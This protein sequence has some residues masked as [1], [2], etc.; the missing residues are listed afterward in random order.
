VLDGTRTYLLEA[1]HKRPGRSLPLASQLPDYRPE[2][3][4]N[5]ESYWVNAGSPFTTEYSDGR[6]QRRSGFLRE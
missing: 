3:M 1:T 4:F 2:A 6:W 5:R